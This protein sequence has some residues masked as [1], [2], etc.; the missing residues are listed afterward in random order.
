MNNSVLEHRSL[1]E[2]IADDLRHKIL[3]K[4][5]QPGSRLDVPSIAGAYG[6][7]PGSVREA[8]IVL[9]SEGLVVVSPRRGIS[10]RVLTSVDLL[11]IYA[12]R[13][14]I[15]VAAAGIVSGDDES[16]LDALRAAQERIEQ[17]WAAGGF[18][19]GLAADLDFHV[20]LAD[21]SGNS[22]LA[23][24]SANLADQTRLHLQPVEELDASIRERPPSD[25]HRA[26]VDAIASGEQERIRDAFARHYAFS[27]TRVTRE[28]QQVPGAASRP[29]G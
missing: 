17:E 4:A 11:E 1:R 23:T 26:I 20:R 24:I 12:V 18:A 25:L 7:S 15:D 28:G 10:V 2:L 22:R 9:E 13:E 3:T 14:V 27:R 6:V 29:G 19:A 8:A 5:L 16:V 21:L